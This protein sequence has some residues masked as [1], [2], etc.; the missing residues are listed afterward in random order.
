MILR[1]TE[2]SS[3]IRIL[4][5]RKLRSWWSAGAN[6]KSKATAHRQDCLCYLHRQG[7]GGTLE[8]A[9]RILIRTWGRSILCGLWRDST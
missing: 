2:E 3:T 5:L 4:S 6:A 8:A 1:M 9:E 7:D